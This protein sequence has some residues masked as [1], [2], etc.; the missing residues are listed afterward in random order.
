MAKPFKLADAFG[1]AIGLELARM[2]VV[3]TNQPHRKSLRIS[4]M[5]EERTFK[6]FKFIP[7]SHFKIY[8]YRYSYKWIFE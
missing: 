6:F 1:N 2:T 8:V 4:Q 5:S 7:N 3:G